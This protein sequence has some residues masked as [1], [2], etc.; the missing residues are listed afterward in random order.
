MSLKKEL[1]NR[2][3]EDVCKI[4]AYRVVQGLWMTLC[5]FD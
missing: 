3:C 5:E 4:E 1:W 2:Y